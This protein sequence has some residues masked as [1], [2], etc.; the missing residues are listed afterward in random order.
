M[1]Q[2]LSVARLNL[3]NADHHHQPTMI[4][5]EMCERLLHKADLLEQKRDIKNALKGGI[6]PTRSGFDWNKR[7]KEIDEQLKEL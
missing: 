4:P 2:A 7:L 6:S 5:K 3:K 1:I